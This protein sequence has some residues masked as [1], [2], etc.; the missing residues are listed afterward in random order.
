MYA[1]TSYIYIYIYIYIVFYVFVY[2][3][4]I[5]CVWVYIYIYNNIED[6]RRARSGKERARPLGAFET[7][8]GEAWVKTKASGI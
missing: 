4:I 3:Y 5:V 1:H 7:P 6:S 2:M 8:G